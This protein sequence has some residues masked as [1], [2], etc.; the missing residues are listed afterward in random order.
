MLVTTAMMPNFAAP[1]LYLFTL[2]RFVNTLWN[3]MRNEHMFLITDISNL[4]LMEIAGNNT[5]EDLAD[6]FSNINVVRQVDTTSH[7]AVMEYIRSYLTTRGWDVDIDTFT[8]STPIGMKTFRNIISSFR[9]PSA[10]HL[11]LACHYDSKLI[12]G[13]VGSI[14][15]AMPCSILLKIADSLTPLLVRQKRMH[16]RVKLVFLDGEEAFKT[17]S[18]NDSLYGARHLASLWAASGPDGRTELSKIKLFVL[19]DLIGSA[20]MVIPPYSDNHKTAYNSL[21]NIEHL[22]SVASLL[23][24]NGDGKHKYFHGSNHPQYEDDHVPFFQRGVP[25]LHLIPYPLPEVWHRLSDN[26]TNIDWDSSMD[27]LNIVN[28]FTYS[29]LHL[30]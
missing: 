6:I 2:F 12:A 20:G 28:A 16:L 13:F 11:I 5:R 1:L 26:A 27:I 7:G 14:D 9:S 29:V 19:L 21:R 15:S 22:M 4:T 25:I 18:Y 3:G 10:E 8:Q 23:R 24:G 17:W 30:M